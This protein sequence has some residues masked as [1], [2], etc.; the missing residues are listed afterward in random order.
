MVCD[1]KKKCSIPEDYHKRIERFV[2]R[3][4]VESFLDGIACEYERGNVFP[5]QEDVFAALKLTPFETVCVVIVGQ[6]PYHDDGQAHGLAFSVPFGVRIPPSLKN[7]YKEIESDCGVSKQ[8][9]DG[10]LTYL[11][12]QGVLLLNSVM[13]VEAH[14]PVSHKR[15]GWEM[16]T[17]SIIKALSLEQERIVFMLW[18]EFAKSKRALI[19]ESKHLVLV[20]VHPSPLSAYK[21]FFGCKHFSLSNTYLRKANKNGILW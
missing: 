5:K 17:D 3:E 20:S 18:G 1:M 10:N 2:E 19:D 7:I 11:A 12:K 4:N 21:G 6:D 16:I 14:K 15:K 13:T 8:G 9:S